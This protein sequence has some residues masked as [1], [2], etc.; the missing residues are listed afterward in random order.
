MN[1]CSAWKSSPQW[2]AAEAAS[3]RAMATLAA[4]L[5]ALCKHDLVRGERGVLLIIAPDQRQ[6]SIVLGLCEAAFEQ[7][8]ILRQLIARQ[9]ERCAHADQRHPHRSSRVELPSIFVD[10]LTS[11]SSLTK[12]RS[13][14]AT[15]LPRMPMLKSSTRCVRVLPPLAAR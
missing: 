4:Y 14:T 6:A 1:R 13:G 2:L 8:P 5:A 11:P 15:R 10:Q 9:I 12:R 3:R 7:S